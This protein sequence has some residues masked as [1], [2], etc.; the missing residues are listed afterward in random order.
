MEVLENAGHAVLYS[1]GHFLDSLFINFYHINQSFSNI[2]VL[3]NSID[4]QAIQEEHSSIYELINIDNKV[5]VKLLLVFSA[6]CKEIELLKKE[7]EAIFLCK[8]LEYGEN[9]TD[10]INIEES[11]IAITQFLPDLLDILNFV[12]RCRQV[13]IHFLRQLFSSLEYAWKKGSHSIMY[14]KFQEVFKYLDDLF[15]IFITLDVGLSFYNEGKISRDLNLLLQ[16]IKLFPNDSGK[17]QINKVV[18]DIINELFSGS[19][20][21]GTLN[22]LFEKKLFLSQSNNF[23]T[24]FNR[25]LKKKLSDIENFKDSDVPVLRFWSQIVSSHVFVTKCFGMTDKK[26]HKNVLETSKKFLAVPLFGDLIWI[27]GKFLAEQ[28]ETRS[29]D[30]P[31]KYFG[32][33]GL[34]EKRLELMEVNSLKDLKSYSL[35]VIKW[36]LQMENAASSDANFSK[37]SNSDLIHLGIEG[38]QLTDQMKFYIDNILHLHGMHGRPMTKMLVLNVCKL[39]ELLKGIQSIFNRHSPEIAKQI[40]HIFQKRVMQILSMILK[41]KKEVF[42]F[43]YQEKYMDAYSSL[44]LAERLLYGSCSEDRIL[45]VQLALTL[46]NDYP[47]IDSDANEKILKL[48]DDLYNLCLFTS[49]FEKFEL[50]NFMYIEEN[51]FPIYF[52]HLMDTHSNTARLQYILHSTSVGTTQKGNGKFIPERKTLVENKVIKELCEEIEVHLRLHAH[53]HLKNDPFLGVIN[54]D[55]GVILHDLPINMYKWFITIKGLVESYLN[56]TFYDLTTVALHDWQTYS[57]MKSLAKHQFKLRTLEDNLPSQTVSQGLDVL[58]IMR[59]IHVFV[60]KYL[61]NLNTQCFIEYI[62]ANKHLNTVNIHQIAN[63]IW[64]HGTGIMNTTVNFIYQFLRRKL[65]HC[66]Q[67]LYDEHINSRLTKDLKYFNQQKILKKSLYPY[68]RAEKFNKGI[69]RL[70]ISSEGLSYLDQYRILISQIGNALGYVR[71]IH[72]GGLHHSVASMSYFPCNDY[73]AISEN[74]KSNMTHNAIDNFEVTL[75]NALYHLNGETDALK[76]LVEVFYSVFHT[77]ENDHL[78]LF[79]MIIPPLTI[80]FVNYIIAAKEK[81][82]KR[83]STSGLFTDDG[84]VIGVAYLLSVFNLSEEF[85]SL[86]WFESVSEKYTADECNI[87]RSMEKQEK[88]DTTNGNTLQLSIKRLQMYKQEF[89]LLKCNLSSAMVFFSGDLP[90]S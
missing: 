68:E 43:S 17:V 24:H 20:F 5:Q 45:L 66:S 58:E 87:L 51:I 25:Y 53:S 64:T 35:W 6:I 36:T 71:M 47:F 11:Q 90:Q 83:N 34:L 85:N 39:I 28:F 9:I 18:Q 41:V 73:I 38:L 80:N 29:I 50:L 15:I 21:Q 40:N 84:F 77:P 19:I 76:L 63:S 10:D 79:V 70:K 12:R 69:S 86:H 44:I 78:R 23:P 60:G 82:S 33:S 52:K 74:N 14:L 2:N 13:L 46:T 59:N 16:H 54:K 32:L 56:K 48:I 65:L 4:I 57:E 88:D 7:L 55:Y 27:P 26:L 61:Y 67:F 49:K 8:I 62:S 30:L 31:H 22:M 81:M 75:F 1:Y 89:E 72:S 42:K 37:L 3:S